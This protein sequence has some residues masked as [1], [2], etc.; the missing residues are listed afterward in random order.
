V[1]AASAAMER[2]VKPRMFLGWTGWPPLS[3]HCHT[4]V[5]S[6]SHLCHATVVP[7]QKNLKGRQRNARTRLQHFLPLSTMIIYILF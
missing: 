4:F 1:P 5:M 2:W 7:L 6:L 3:R